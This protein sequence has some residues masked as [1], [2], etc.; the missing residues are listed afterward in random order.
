MIDTKIFNDTK[1][2]FVLKSDEDLKRALFLFS[3]MNVP[4]FVPVSTALT[5]FALNIKLPIEPLVKATIFKQFCGGVSQDD[6]MPLVKK[7]HKENVYTVLDYS[8]EGKE[9]EEEFDKAANTKI[10]IIKY[11]SGVKEIPFAVAKPTGLG[12]FEIWEK[13]TANDTLTDEEQAEWGRIKVRF[14]KVCQAAYDNDTKLLIDAEESWMQDAADNLIEDMMRK[15]NK[16]KA[17]I[18]NT[19]QCYRWDRL[20]YVKAIHERAQEEGFKLGFKTVRG[21]YMEKE[22]AR[23]KKHGYPTPICEDKEATDVNFNAVMC[24]CIDN[25]NDISQFIGTHN[26]VSSYMALQLMSQKDLHLSDD[27]IWFGQLYGMSDHISFNLGRENA[28]AIKLMPF[29]PIKDVIPYLIRRAQENSSVQGQTGRELALLRE[30]KH[31]RDGQYVKR[32]E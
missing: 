7:M 14:E 3:M 18:F 28:N 20:S 30:E 24:Y 17:I 11:A 6:C 13:V 19:L 15:F 4:Y 9:S 23:A 12:R 31:R 5:N 25:V 26:E 2:A 32:V 21:A 29:G 22:N 8:V 27:R 10:E 16:E 1:H